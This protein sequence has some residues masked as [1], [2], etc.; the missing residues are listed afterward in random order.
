MLHGDNN[1][2]S[3]SIFTMKGA[4]R[5]VTALQTMA[6]KQVS[7][8]HWSPVGRFFVLAGLKGHNGA[9]EFWDADENALLSTGEH[10]MAGSLE[11][12]PTG[13]YV[14]TMVDASNNMDNGFNVWSFSG[15]LLYKV[16]RERL[17]QFAWRPRPPMLISEEKQKEIQR[18]LKR[19]S[20]RY[21][22][23]DERLLLS[24]DA[25]F[26]AEREREM[27][28]WR[29]WLESR[30]EWIEQERKDVEALLGPEKLARMNDYEVVK[31]EVSVVVDTKEEV[32]KQ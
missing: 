16:D 13:R 24:A 2:L 1:R 22:E 14:V 10:F 30:K 12:D 15:Q 32:I 4:S 20:K 19:Y 11:W 8:V 3:A 18:N 28:N 31:A 25:E 17:F 9:L 21:D 6:N 27:N 5:G 23:E 26:L 7:S 29:E